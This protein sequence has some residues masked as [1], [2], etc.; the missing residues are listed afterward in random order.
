MD[1]KL[2]YAKLNELIDYFGFNLNPS[3][4][5]FYYEQLKY[6]RDY[7]FNYA[8]GEIMRTKKPSR[9]NFPSIDDIQAICPR[10]AAAL[11]YN[12]DETE[13][14]HWR[15][16]TVKHLMEAT[17]IFI[18]QGEESMMAYARVHH[19]N[20]DDIEA[21]TH[22]ATGKYSLKDLPEVGKEIPKVNHKERLN[23]LRQQ[24]QKLG[25]SIPF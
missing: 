20:Q 1:T 19:F 23:E 13:E 9:G 10:G 18:K 2:F 16:V 7:D 15:R 22:K 4:Q 6:I 17:N 14:E 25:A 21:V 11:R 24:A 8:A 3:Q 12:P 5:K